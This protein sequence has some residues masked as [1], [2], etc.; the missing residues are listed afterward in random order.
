[1]ASHVFSSDTPCR[2]MSSVTQ[3]LI[4]VGALDW[5]L[6]APRHHAWAAGILRPMH[7]ANREGGRGKRHAPTDRP[8]GGNSSSTAPAR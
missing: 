2:G 7:D 1:M 6:A 8:G 4:I 3:G 5:L